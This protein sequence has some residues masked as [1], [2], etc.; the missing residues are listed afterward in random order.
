MRT[1]LMWLI[2]A[3]CGG[4]IDGELLAGDITIQY[5]SSS[6][7]LEV[8]TAVRAEADGDM[9]V[10]IGSNN[11][12]C[13]T[14]LDMFISFDYPEGTFVYF[15]VS[16]SMPGTYPNE[17]VDFMKSGSRNTSINGT[18]GMVTIESIDTRVKGT[19]VATT[20][21]EEVGTLSVQGSFDVVSCL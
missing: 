3:A 5:G 7:K 6:P 21:D 13:D 19:V 11:V 9:L 18:L 2:L 15:T 14:Y 20:T 8:G 1:A 16:S 12:D 10:Q 4:G 17:P